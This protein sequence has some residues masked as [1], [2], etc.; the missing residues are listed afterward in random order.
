MIVL[1]NRDFVMGMKIC[2]VLDSHVIHTAQDV[3]KIIPTIRPNQLILANAYVIQL[4][5]RLESFAN[6]V[7]I[8]DELS[9]FERIDDLQNIIRTAVGRDMDL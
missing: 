6:L 5:P 4:Y 9:D 2:G 7:T 8:P 3:A 1:G